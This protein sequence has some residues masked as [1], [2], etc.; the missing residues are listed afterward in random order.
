VTDLPTDRITE[1]VRDLPLAIRGQVIIRELP[2]VRTMETV[3]E[4]PLDRTD[5]RM[6]VRDPLRAIRTEPLRAD[7]PVALIRMTEDRQALPR[8]PL[9][10]QRS[11]ADRTMPLP[12]REVLPESL[13]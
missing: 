6:A 5:L 4:L 12:R 7:V 3:S 9:R 1:T 8:I 2:T 13:I 10:E 11:C